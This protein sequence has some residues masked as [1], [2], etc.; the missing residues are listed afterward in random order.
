LHKSSGSYLD[1]I[2]WRQI[3]TRA[4]RSD[5]G[6]YGLLTISSIKGFVELVTQEPWLGSFGS[7]VARS[8]FVFGRQKIDKWSIKINPTFTF[9]PKSH[10]DH[11]ES[12]VSLFFKRKISN[13]PI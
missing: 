5:G 10:S 8:D 1:Y 13:L 3:H 6:P 4:L 2:S 7:Y 12:I 11:Y 9:K